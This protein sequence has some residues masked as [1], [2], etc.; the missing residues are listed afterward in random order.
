MRLFGDLQKTCEEEALTRRKANDWISDKSWRLIAHRAMLHCTGRLCQMGGHCLHHQIG[1]SLR[2]DWAERTLSVGTLIESELTLG[3]VHEALRHLKGWYRAAS[4]TQAKPCRQTM[5]RQTGEWVDL[6]TWRQSP[7]EPLPIN[8]D[9]VDIDDD[10]PSNGELRVAVG[11]L[12]NGRAAGASG[13][14]AEHIKAWLSDMRWE[15]DPNDQGTDGAGD[16]WCLFM[17]LVQAAWTHVV[18]LS[19]GG[20]DYHGIGLLEPI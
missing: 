14:R 8:I 13:M 20:G 6:Y 2:T 5:D 1:K 18:L 10:I 7:G 17:R 16:N 19:K 11:K 9:P 3:N 12:T 15:E 4:E